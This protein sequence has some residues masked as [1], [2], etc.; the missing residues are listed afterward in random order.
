MPLFIVQSMK[1]T[2]KVIVI[3]CCAT[4]A[5]LITVLGSDCAVHRY[6]VHLHYT[7]C[8]LQQDR[9]ILTARYY[10]NYCSS[11]HLETRDEKRTTYWF[12]EKEYN[13]PRSTKTIKK[14]DT[15]FRRSRFC[16]TTQPHHKV[17]SCSVSRQST[18]TV[19]FLRPFSNF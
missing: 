19:R 13:K 9:A 14:P 12:N 8:C 10:G 16:S 2:E 7:L 18:Q 6:G 11:S 1:A 5:L 15:S 17:Q 3:K 4:L